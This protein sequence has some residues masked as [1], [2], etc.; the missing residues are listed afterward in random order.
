M[1]PFFFVI[2][3]E[4]LL[5]F[6]KYTMLNCKKGKEEMYVH[7][8]ITD[9]YL[10]QMSIIEIVQR[11]TLSIMSNILQNTIWCT[12]PWIFCYFQ[13]IIQSFFKFNEYT[14]KVKHI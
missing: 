4:Y 8:I 14:L 5:L 6:I 13:P 11:H 3:F 2:Y 9:K 10:E 12:K 1:F 7:I